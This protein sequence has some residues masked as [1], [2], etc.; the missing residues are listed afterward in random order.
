MRLAN[1]ST[2]RLTHRTCRVK[3]A[4]WARPEPRCHL[5]NRAIDNL[6]SS[7]VRRMGRSSQRCYP[8]QPASGSIQIRSSRRIGRLLDSAYRR[9]QRADS[10]RPPRRPADF[11]DRRARVVH[12]QGV[13]TIAGAPPT[14]SRHSLRFAGTDDPGNASRCTPTAAY[15][16]SFYRC[17]AQIVRRSSTRLHE[18]RRLRLQHVVGSSAEKS[19]QSERQPSHQPRAKD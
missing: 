4:R 17:D 3:I 19:E 9:E 2:R 15:R 13:G 12:R 6:E 8:N 5:A 10:Y 11:R 18:L 14:C 7:P 1:S 16:A